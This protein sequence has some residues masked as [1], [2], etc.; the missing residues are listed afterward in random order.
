MTA[1]QRSHATKLST[2]VAIVIAIAVTVLHTAENFVYLR[3]LLRIPDK[4]LAQAAALQTENAFYYAYYNELVHAPS[5]KEGLSQ[6]IWDKRSEYPDVLNA[7]RRF[8]V[9]QEVVLALQY[10]FLQACRLDFVDEWA[11]SVGTSLC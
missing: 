5:L 8:N 1:W 6:I 10:R 11:F 3:H 2:T 9:Y 4:G 7:L